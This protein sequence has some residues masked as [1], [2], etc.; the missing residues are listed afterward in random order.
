MTP[1]HNWDE[2]AWPPPYSPDDIEAAHQ[3]QMA[4]E[5]RQE[6]LFTASLALQGILAGAPRYRL[7]DQQDGQPVVT[8]RGAAE[9]AL[10]YADALLRELEMTQ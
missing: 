8:P 9:N 2:H 5:R 4:Q 3:Q 1:T 7:N 10:Q 6:R